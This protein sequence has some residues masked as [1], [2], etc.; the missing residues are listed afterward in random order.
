MGA[1]N[2]GIGILS[3]PL[4]VSRDAL[5]A[6]W[7]RPSVFPSVKGG[8]WPR[9]VAGPDG[10]R[11][12]REASRGKI[13][14]A[15]LFPKKFRPPS[16]RT[17][18][19][20]ASGNSTEPASLGVKQSA[21]EG[22]RGDRTAIQ[23][24][25]AVNGGRAATLGESS[26][27]HTSPP[28]PHPLPWP[29]PPAPSSSPILPRPAPAGRPL[30]FLARGRGN[31]ERVTS[32]KDEL[33]RGRAGGGAGGGLGRAAAP[34]PPPRLR[35]RHVPGRVRPPGASFLW[36]GSRRPSRPHVALPGRGAAARGCRA[37]ATSLAPLVTSGHL[38]NLSWQLGGSNNL[39]WAPASDARSRVTSQS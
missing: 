34:W 33:T 27:A 38:L 6:K 24:A 20:E 23:T 15:R 35:W 11:I 7:L 10:M 21:D 30:R 19:R 29:P 4:V 37:T 39:R 8:Y 22:I 14:C 2:G 5:F 36:P 25:G 26:F 9:R 32:R 13:I 31:A 28:G 12:K 1:D 18:P 3:F 17:C 16:S